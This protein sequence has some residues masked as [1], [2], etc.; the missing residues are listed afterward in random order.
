MSLEPWSACRDHLSAGAA[1]PRNS[2]DAP[3]DR[4]EGLEIAK[5]ASVIK[6]SFLRETPVPVDKRAVEC[7]S[8]PALATFSIGLAFILFP[9][10]WR[11]IKKNGFL[12][13]V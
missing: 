11:N 8:G 13:N 6:P 1:P 3:F 9:R 5:V 12:L 4:S 2:D 7:S 10:V